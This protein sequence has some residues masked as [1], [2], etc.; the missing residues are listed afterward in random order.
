ME[1]LVA[2]NQS[3]NP[4]IS[5]EAI[6]QTIIPIIQ[7]LADRAHQLLEYTEYFFGGIFGLYLVFF[8]IRT[9]IDHRKNKILKEI[10]EEV[11]N[12]NKKLDK[13]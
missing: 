8:I 5:Q 11:Q 7:P 1:E 13:K 3:I 10:K 2:I 12:I 4:E 6:N 9:I